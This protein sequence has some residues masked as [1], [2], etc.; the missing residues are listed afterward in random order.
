[1]GTSGCF[2]GNAV[3]RR[4]VCRRERQS[5]SGEWEHERQSMEVCRKVWYVGKRIV[6]PTLL[7]EQFT[8]IHSVIYI[9]QRRTQ[10][11][12]IVQERS[13][14]Y[15]SSESNSAPSI[16]CR[17]HVTALLVSLHITPNTKRL[18]APNLR[19]AIWLLASVRVAVVLPLV[20]G[21][22]QFR[23]RAPLIKV[24]PPFSYMRITKSLI[25]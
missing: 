25:G 10:V 1:M 20:N 12:D 21:K 9:S 8:I 24:F 5:C 15:T 14:R 2:L 6:V 7:S 19:T 23:C 3:E 17:P 18:S 22:S 13:V 11:S 4:T 16:L